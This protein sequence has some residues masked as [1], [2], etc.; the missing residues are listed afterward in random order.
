MHS[1]FH[2]EIA[3]VLISWKPIGR[4]SQLASF[5][6]HSRPWLTVFSTI[7][8]TLFSSYWIPKHESRRSSFDSAR[9][10]LTGHDILQPCNLI[11]PSIALNSTVY[12]RAFSFDGS[13]RVAWILFHFCNAIM[14]RCYGRPKQNDGRMDGLG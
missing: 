13:G 5:A 14:V 2:I 8:I 3:S 9:N 4:T 12:T 1:I 7:A 10:W 11:K 6:G